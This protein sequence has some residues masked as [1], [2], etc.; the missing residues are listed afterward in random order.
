MPRTRMEGVVDANKL[1]KLFAGTMWLL[2]LGVGKSHLISGLGHALIDA[3]RRV[4][5]VRCSELVQRLQTA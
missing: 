2:R 3:G 5:F 1:C 4:L